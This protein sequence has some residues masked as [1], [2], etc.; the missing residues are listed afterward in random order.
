M[1]ILYTVASVGRF[2][3][4]IVN[5]D[6]LDAC[7]LAGKRL[8]HAPFV[9]EPPAAAKGADEPKKSEKKTKKT[10]PTPASEPVD[11]SQ[12]LGCCCSC[13]DQAKLSCDWC[14]HLH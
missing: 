5:L 3:I 7:E 4:P 2:G 13:H 12:D 1:S 11:T 9:Q 14:A 6:Y 8:P 10:R